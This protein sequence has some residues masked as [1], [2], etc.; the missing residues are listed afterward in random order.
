MSGRSSP[1]ASTADARR[2]M[3][4]NRGQDTRPERELRTEL[5]RRGLRFRLQ[6]PIVSG[7][8][9]KVDIVFP[10]ARVAVFVDGCFWHGCPRHGTSPKS[11]AAFWTEKI[12]ANQI[13][14]EDTNLRLAADGWKVIRV[15]EHE[16][17]AT[18]AKR[19]HRSVEARRRRRAKTN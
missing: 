7:V 2:R 13:R 14:D 8:R 17:P 6:R 16:D 11:N 3:Q 9:R 15:W 18:A 4:A 5:H 10:S 12:E 19:I 1:P